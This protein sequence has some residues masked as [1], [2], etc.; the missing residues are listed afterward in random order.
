M[1]EKLST[2]AEVMFG[3][4]EAKCELHRWRLRLRCTNR[5]AEEILA[6]LRDSGLENKWRDSKQPVHDAISYLE[7]TTPSACASP[8]PC[9]SVCRLAAALSRSRARPWSVS[10]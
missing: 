5:A 7:R 6:E 4:Q 9:V 1:I 3:A 10:A 2:A 8:G